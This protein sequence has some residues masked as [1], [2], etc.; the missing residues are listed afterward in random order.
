MQTGSS[1]RARLTCVCV[2]VHNYGGS[3]TELTVRDKLIDHKFD[4]N[5]F[6]NLQGRAYKGAIEG[7]GAP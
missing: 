4:A 2:R 3:Q 5:Q 1:A 6:T 7:V